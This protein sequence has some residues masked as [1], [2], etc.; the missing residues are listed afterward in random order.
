M[1][2]NLQPQLPERSLSEDER[3]ACAEL[4]KAFAANGPDEATKAKHDAE[5][6]NW[7]KRKATAE[8]QT[9][10]AAA[11]ERQSAFWDEHA[12]LVEKLSEMQAT[13]MDGLKVKARL[14][15]MMDEEDLAW[16]IVEDLAAAR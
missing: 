1:R 4:Q 16:S 8:C 3:R 14:A 5:R 13:T 2:Q 12:L 15:L 9:G 6:A 7:E 10:K 11:H